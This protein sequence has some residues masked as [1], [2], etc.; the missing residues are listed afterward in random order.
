MR[1]EKS[2]DRVLRLKA[3]FDTK[4]EARVFQSELDLLS[5]EVPFSL[6]KLIVDSEL[7][8]VTDTSAYHLV[9][10]RMKEY[11]HDDEEDSPEQ[12]FTHTVT[13]STVPINDDL[14][15]FQSP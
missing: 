3:I 15:M 4:K 1:P 12:T 14:V 8:L 7:I 9:P 5:E 11:N 10:L 13:V 2:S 6:H